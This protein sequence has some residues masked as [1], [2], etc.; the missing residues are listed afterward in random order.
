MLQLDWTPAKLGQLRVK[1]GVRLRGEQ[2]NRLETFTDAAF[3]F[4]VTLLVISV[5]DVPNSYAEFLSA[6]E[7]VPAFV[8]CFIQLMVFWWGHH[9]WSRRYGLE[10]GWDIVLGLGLV[11][12]VLVYIYPLR[13]IFTAFVANI[14]NGTLGESFVTQ[15]QLGE[16]FVTFGLFFGL[17]AGVLVLHFVRAY[18]L[19]ERLA[20]N[21]R[22]RVETW[23]DVVTWSVVSLTG[24][25]SMSLALV[26]PDTL[27]P[28]AA[29]TYYSLSVTLPC[30]G[31]WL[32]R[33]RQRLVLLAGE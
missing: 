11:A 29:Y 3:A 19:R 18:V 12:T 28:S 4:A 31:Y 16:M 27:K 30:V 13:I 1:N 10:E 2:M 33:R 17:L 9:V 14:S 32:A 20:L 21:A 15:S 23:G 5:D 26:L 22:E 7:G 25:V 6:L 24:F 8:M